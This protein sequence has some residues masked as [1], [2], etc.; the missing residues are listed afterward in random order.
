MDLDQILR[1]VRTPGDTIK[2][3][4]GH[5]WTTRGAWGFEDLGF[6]GLAPGVTILAEGS[7]ILL[8]DPIKETGGK[9]RPEKDLVFPWLGDGATIIGGKWD[10]M[11]HD[12]W[13]RS[14]FHCLGDATLSGV[15]L[16]N[17]RG[18]KG[19]AGPVKESFALS[20]EGRGTQVLTDCTTSSPDV[21]GGSDSY[22]AG[23]YPNQ[24]KVT[25]CKVDHGPHGWFGF[26]CVG[27]T[28]FV[29]CESESMHWWY[30]DWSGGNAVIRNPKGVAHYA[31]I[32]VRQQGRREVSV[33]GGRLTAPRG[34]EWAYGA[35]EGFVLFS[36]VE[37][38]V[39]HSASID[40]RSGAVILA[41]CTGKIGPAHVTDGSFQ[42]VVIQ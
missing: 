2:L 15:N 10:S 6:V 12:G 39:G 24:G 20:T 28:E 29:D 22:V 17:Q 18:T 11:R 35:S 23:W 4:S 27:P 26:S 3:E 31:A 1:M 42:P 14:G 30:T 32:G 9:E 36:G 40:A 41:N 7:E 21:A 16:Y 5:V 19:G 13:S 8:V 38:D 34:V 37:L 25:R 33:L